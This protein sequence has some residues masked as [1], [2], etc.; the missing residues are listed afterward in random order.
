[1][2]GPAMHY[3]IGQL[4]ANPEMRLH[5]GGQPTSIGSL[6]ANVRRLLLENP[7]AFNV[8]TLGPDFLFFNTVDWPN[9]VNKVAGHLTKVTDEIIFAREKVAESIPLVKRTVDLKKTAGDLIQKA[10]DASATFDE[11][12]TV[13]DNLDGLLSLL[14]GTLSNSI[15]D[16]A[17]SNINVFGL[18][19][20]PITNCEPNDDWWW[21]DILHYAKT[22][23]FARQLLNNSRGSDQAH[24][25]AVG[26]LSHVTADTVGHPYVNNVVRGPYRNHSQRHKVVEN[27]QDV[28]M[29]RSWYNQNRQFMTNEQ[30]IR[31]SGEEF[32]ASELARLFRYN[33]DVLHLPE[34]DQLRRTDTILSQLLPDKF[35]IEL[36]DNIASLISR[37]AHHTYGRSFGSPIT[38]KQVQ[39]SY[40]LW[41]RWFAKSTIEGILPNSLDDLPP[42]D[43]TIKEWLDD[44]LN[45]LK[46]TADAWKDVFSG[47]PSFSTK[48]IRNFFKKVGRALAETAR[49]AYELIDKIKATMQA[50]PL[51]V[52]NWGI[53]TLYQQLYKLYDYFRLSVSL[54]GFAFPATRH[55][56]DP[57]IL[58]MTQPQLH[59]DA[60]GNALRNVHFAYPLQP[61]KVG[62]IFRSAPQVAHL[63][64]PPVRVE[65]NQITEAPNTYR[66]HSPEYYADGPIGFN[67]KVIDRLVRLPKPL[68]NSEAQSEQLGNAC[69]L[70]AA[71]YE[72][73]MENVPLPD[74]N[75][76]GDRGMAAPCWSVA[77]CTVDARVDQVNPNYEDDKV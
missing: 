41:Y 47:S 76:D 52:L 31:L 65:K 63:V 29:Y 58:H 46:R 45:Q 24:A 57:R 68:P 13:L 42:L 5:R 15:K 34:R 20:S 43:Q 30:A 69:R 38:A 61:A 17:T 53:K 50:I 73:F 71:Y 67:N 39:E 21:F 56:N 66:F 60:N 4:L 40:R 54:N 2:P 48:G 28:A 6:P 16:L 18:L 11:M 33:R 27:F 10:R 51:R 32:V 77:N 35:N 14:W 23:V 1:M 62:G 49:L 55:L 25:Y 3:V 9:G 36:P 75:L 64:Y 59:S 74:L 26:Y 7:I 72:R 22:G 8:G 12:K 70:T 37:T 44:I 19:E